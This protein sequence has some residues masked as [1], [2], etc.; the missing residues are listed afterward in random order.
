MCYLS[1]SKIMF[2]YYQILDSLHDEAACLRYD[3][4]EH[5]DCLG[6]TSSLALDVHSKIPE[7]SLL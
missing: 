2:V 7:L 5:G 4:A 1:D 3:F 6:G